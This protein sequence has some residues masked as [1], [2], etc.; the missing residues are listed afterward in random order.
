MGFAVPSQLTARTQPHC[1]FVFLRSRVC[2]TLLSASPRGY[3]LRF[4]TVAVIGPGWLLSSNKILPMLGTLGQ[5]SRPVLRAERAFGATTGREACPTQRWKSCTKFGRRSQSLRVLP[6][7]GKGHKSEAAGQEVTRAPVSRK[8]L[9][10]T[11]RM[12]AMASPP[13]AGARRAS[14]AHIPIRRR[15]NSGWSVNTA[16]SAAL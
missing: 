9:P 16:I 11:A 15:W 13:A 14:S 8:L 10:A 7:E 4:T 12:R 6:L 2:Y 5:A 3:A 1:Q